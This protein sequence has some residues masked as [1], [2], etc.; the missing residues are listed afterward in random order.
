MTQI[1]FTIPGVPIA[2]PRAKATAFAGRVQMYTPKKNASG[3][4]NGVA[5]FRSLLQLIASQH[6]SGA[7]LAG[8]LRVDIEFVFPRQGNMVWK[9]KPMPRYRHTTKPDRDNLDKMCLDSL[10][11]ILWVDDNQVCSGLI[12][13]WH[14][15]G[16][17]SPH[18]TITVTEIEATPC[19]R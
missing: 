17:E 12:D 6:K 13:K 10:K 11:G 19:Q 8:P 5:E 2:Q 16:D 9:K 15:A 4:S 18:T 1:K 14:A 3:K 7:L